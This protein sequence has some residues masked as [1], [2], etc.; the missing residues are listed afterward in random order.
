MAAH[1]VDPERRDQALTRGSAAILAKICRCDATNR[2][3]ARSLFAQPMEE[4]MK[5]LNLVTLILVIIGGL[6]LGIVGLAGFDVIAAV[7]GGAASALSRIVY[8]IIGLSALWQIVPLVWAFGEGEVAS[9]R[10][11]GA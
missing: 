11:L 2:E 10:H 7:F 1:C 9:E 3:L 8:I 6:D 5:V 4:R